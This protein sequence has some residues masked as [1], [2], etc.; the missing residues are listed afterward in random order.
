MKPLIL[1]ADDERFFRKIV[2]QILNEKYEIRE[3]V[4]GCDVIEQARLW[5]PKLVIMDLAMPD[6]N[7]LE[8]IRKIRNER[9]SCKILACTV[10]VAPHYRDSA[11]ACGADAFLPKKMIFSQLQ[12]LVD[13]LCA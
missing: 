1:V 2:L 5:R 4:N 11:L 10:H 9:L 3:A 7:G 12:P 6:C 8:A 13:K